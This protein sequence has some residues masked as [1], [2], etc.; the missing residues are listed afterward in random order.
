[1]CGD[2]LL[3]WLLR[4]ARARR[5]NEG[6][7]AHCGVGRRRRKGGC[8][9]RKGKRREKMG[10]GAAAAKM[11]LATQPLKLKRKVLGLGGFCFRFF[12]L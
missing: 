4:V 6:V 8:D 12:F 1:M 5:V 11:G 2:W 3:L 10:E 9:V 7:G